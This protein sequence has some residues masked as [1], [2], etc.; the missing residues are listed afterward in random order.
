MNVVNA[1]ELCFFKWL[2]LKI[3][4]YIYFTTIKG[5]GE[6]VVNWMRKNDNSKNNFLV[7]KNKNLKL[8]A[9][10][11]CQVNDYLG[12]NRIQRSKRKF[13][14]GGDS[15]KHYVDCRD[16]FMIYTYIRIH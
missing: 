3:L 9:N 2:K 8:Q 13:G 10:L 6:E 15:Y 14:E 11:L 7:V 12:R 5:W 16:G 4:C 1:T